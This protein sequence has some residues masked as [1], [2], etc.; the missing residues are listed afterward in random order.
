VGRESRCVSRAEVD[1]RGEGVLVNPDDLAMELH[2]LATPDLSCAWWW[3]WIQPGSSTDLG[4]LRCLLDS[5]DAS[6]A[7]SSVS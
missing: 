5:G 4:L 1:I 7:F 2:G 6:L 3:W